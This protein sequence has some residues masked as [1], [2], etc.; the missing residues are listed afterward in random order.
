MQ[1]DENMVCGAE[2]VQ[3]SLP[4]SYDGDWAVYPFLGQNKVLAG[5]MASGLFVLDA[6]RVAALVKNRVFDWDGD[7]KTDLSVFRA[8]DGSCPFRQ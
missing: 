5:D 4:N 3:N 8:S 7:G 2:R 6:S 1:N